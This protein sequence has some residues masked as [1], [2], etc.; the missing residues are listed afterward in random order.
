MLPVSPSKTKAPKLVAPKHT[1]VSPAAFRLSAKGVEVYAL[2]ISDLH[3][4]GGTKKMTEEQIPV[5]Y[6]DL[7]EPFSE[8]AS[9]E[10]PSHGVSDMEIEFKEGEE[11]R[12]TG[13]RP[14]WN[15]RS[16]GDI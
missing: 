1:I 13:L 9:N 2:E 3:D 15:W 16:F 7:W 12:N 11:P 10:L 6:Q 14:M 8:E 5:E 4:D